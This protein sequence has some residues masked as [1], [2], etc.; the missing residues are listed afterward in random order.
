MS[1]SMERHPLVGAYLDRVCA[2]VKTK[3]VCEDIRVEM[4]SHLEELA[5]EKAA[6]DGMSEEE[7]IAEALLQMG[8][9]ERVGKQLQ[10]VHKPKLEWGVIALVAGMIVIGL[11]SL[12]AMQ[13]SLDGNLPID[14]KLVY[15][16]MGVAA[17]IILYFADYRR[18]IRYSWLLYVVTLLL[19]AAVHWQRVYVNGAAQWLHVGSFSFNVYAAS[20][21][22][23]VIAIAGMLQREQ[24]AMQGIRQE[25]LQ[26]AKDAAVYILIPAYFYV[27]APAFVYFL[28]YGL[29]LAVLLLV[30]GKGKLLFA[31]FGS[32]A[33]LL[34]PLLLG[35][36][37]D[38]AWR[39][40]MAFL[41]PQANEFSGGFYTLRSVEA[42]QSGGM[43]GQGFGIVYGNL[44]H[45]SSEFVYSYLVYSLGW[46]FGIAVAMIALLFIVRIVRMGAKLQDGY[47]K[48]LVVSLSTVLGIQFAW[49]L[50]MCAGLLPI[51]GMTLPIMN[52]HSG[53]MIELAAV[54]LMLG[55]YRRKDMLGRHQLP[56][57]AKV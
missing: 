43:W 6:L 47:A 21:Y 26:L 56:R 32:L 38:F 33:L 18:L 52:W 53:T 12:Y 54:G 9:P 29:G 28:I 37:Y 7:A 57:A 44:P 5:A 22:L 50:L 31:G 49:N 24:P 14:R 23:L 48:G 13:L 25:V 35:R 51:L 17:L 11:I 46:V 45:V 41:H 27:S 1:Q 20:P 3:E 19:M 10:A 55:A 30:S 8:D 42:I 15:G 2:Q 34:S 40:Y 4:L 39:R 36:S 16:F